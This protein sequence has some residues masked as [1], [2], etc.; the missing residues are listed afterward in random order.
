MR[1]TY[2]VTRDG[3]PILAFESMEDAMAAAD[4]IAG[5]D[6]YFAPFI[7]S[8]SET[9]SEASESDSEVPIASIANP[10]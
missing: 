10:Y 3:F 2:V 6:A 8:G 5:A 7:E 1:E 4:A 9:D